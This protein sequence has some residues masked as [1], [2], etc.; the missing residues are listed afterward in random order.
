MVKARRS[1]VWGYPGLHESLWKTARRWKGWWCIQTHINSYKGQYKTRLVKRAPKVQLLFPVGLMHVSEAPTLPGTLSI[2][3]RTQI[4]SGF[5]PVTLILLLWDTVIL[6]T[7]LLLT[8]S[9]VVSLQFPLYAVYC[10]Q[11]NV[12]LNLGNWVFTVRLR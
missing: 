12:H 9:E 10:P 6:I 2:R 11:S 3:T 5:K 1:G 4:P 7:V 8:T